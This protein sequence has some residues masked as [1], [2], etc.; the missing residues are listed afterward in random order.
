[1]Q[2][3]TCSVEE[4]DR[5]PRVRGWCQMHYKRY[6][7]TGDPRAYVQPPPRVYA[8]RVCEQCGAAFLPVAQNQKRCSHRCTRLAAKARERIR[9]F[10]GDVPTTTNCDICGAEFPV[11]SHWQRYCSKKCR[12]KA[13]DQH[14]RYRVASKRKAVYARDNYICQLCWQ[15]VDVSI[16]YPHPRA[17]TLDH[18]IPVSGGGTHDIDNLQLAHMDCNASKGG[19]PRINSRDVRRRL[20][21]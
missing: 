1:M 15:P 18:I 9:A 14:R 17:A 10:D 5:E 4:C 12:G 20:W 7:K 13:K 8:S 2:D 6:L 19:A 3:R 11:I 16:P 21:R